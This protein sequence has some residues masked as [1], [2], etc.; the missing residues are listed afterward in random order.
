MI[1]GLILILALGVQAPPT[2]NFLKGHLVEIANPS[3]NR[4]EY[5]IVTAEDGYVGRSSKPVRV[6]NDTEVRFTIKRGTLYLVDVDGKVQRLRYV[7]QF[8]RPPL[9]PPSKTPN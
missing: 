9:P 2:A 3:H 8:L 6:E 5:T 1:A 4:Y 7:L